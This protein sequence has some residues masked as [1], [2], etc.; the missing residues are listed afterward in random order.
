MLLN[1]LRKPKHK[2]YLALRA[3]AE[4]MI[5][6]KQL[7]P[8]EQLR[9]TISGGSALM[10]SW[11]YS[12]S[13]RKKAGSQ[14]PRGPSMAEFL[15]EISREIGSVQPVVKGKGMSVDQLAERAAI[16]RLILSPKTDAEN[17]VALFKDT[18][19]ARALRSRAEMHQRNV[20]AFEAQKR[21]YQDALSDWEHHGNNPRY[22]E[23]EDFVGLL[24][25]AKTNDR[26]LWHVV[27]CDVERG[28]KVD[29]DAL[30]WILAQPDCDSATVAAFV[31][32]YIAQGYV[33]SRIARESKKNNTQFADTF[34][35]VIERWNDGFYK[36][37]TLD[38]TDWDFE[39]CEP[40]FLKQREKV[41]HM[42]GREP[43]GI[44][45]D[46]F[47]PYPGKSTQPTLYYRH[48]MGLMDLPPRSED[49]FSSGD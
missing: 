15:G 3:P 35:A 25:D 34:A 45:K 42:I 1:L 29:E 32:R 18:N 23:E 27:A 37:E 47:K 44:P 9:N 48:G 14:I 19:A 41:R 38:F 7:P 10:T 16:Y 2:P 5:R 21:A 13:A 28:S 12:E 33:A 31:N 17:V 20:D 39:A 22:H 26:D 30:F 43:W 49:Y 8:V 46:L 40:A 6:R 11:A 24:R 36:T 4:K